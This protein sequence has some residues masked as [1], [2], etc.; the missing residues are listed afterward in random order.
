[1]RRCPGWLPPASERRDER[2]RRREAAAP[3][4]RARGVT[5]RYR[6]TLAVVGLDVDIGHGITGLLGPNGAGKTT[7]ISLVLGLRTR[8][9]GELTV[10]GHDPAT[11]GIDVRAR[12][13]FA[14]EHH[15]L[16]PDVHAADLVRHLGELHGLPAPG[17]D[18]ARERRALAG[19]A[20]RGAIPA[21]RDDVDGPAAARQARRSD[22]PRSR[23]RPAR[24]AHRRPR[25]APARRHAGADPAGRH[26]VRHGHRDLV[27]P[28][29]GGGADLRRR[30]DPRRRRGRAGRDP[31]RAQPQRHGAARRRR[32]RP[33]ARARRAAPRRRLRG[34][35]GGR[36]AQHPRRSTGCTTPSGMPSPI[37]V[38]GSAA[39]LPSARR[40]RTSTWRRARERPG[41]PHLRRRLPGVRRPPQRSGLGARHDLAAHA[42][43]R[44]RA[45][46]GASG[47][48]CC[49]GSRS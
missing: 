16:P 6:S 4:V 12:I 47:T 19:R 30:G 20:R 29:G 1:M 28:P 40:S 38:S 36:G 9:A 7:F 25:S 14:P 13:G 8:D 11:A 15:N 21:D 34:R 27:A 18:P 41:R 10:L 46:T 3:V 23:P 22:R 26:R 2:H 43:A 5:K 35:R 42:P 33:D 37:S 39:S 31:Q 45:C 44:P 48:R 32:R 49:R 17:C 24:R